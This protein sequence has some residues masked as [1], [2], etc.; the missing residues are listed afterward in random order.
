MAKGHVALH[1]AGFFVVLKDA[2]QAPGNRHP[3]ALPGTALL[4]SNNTVWEVLDTPYN[5]I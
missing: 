2:V 1:G 5:Q 3:K 4:G